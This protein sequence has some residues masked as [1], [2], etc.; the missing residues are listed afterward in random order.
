ML[1]CA[2]DGP[3]T[4]GPERSP[5]LVQT[6]YGTFLFYSTTAG[7][8]NQ[9]IYVSQL[10]RDGTFGPG[11]RI[12]ELSTPYYDDLMPN[13]H[14][15]ED[16]ALE[17]YFSSNRPTWGH[18]QPAFG[19]QDVY[20]AYSWWPTKGW[21]SPKNLGSAVNTPGVEQRS[22]LS[23]DGKRLYFGRDGEIFTSNRIGRHDH[24]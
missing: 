5:S 7:G 11:K 21:T 14:V 18:N 17:I 10:D 3:N 16:G 19:G 15:R 6:W 12:A 4:V 24:H 1:P 22:T 9:D 2:P 20:V 13:V 23:H 8:A